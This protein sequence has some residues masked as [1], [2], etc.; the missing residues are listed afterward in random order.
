MSNNEDNVENTGAEE[1][2]VPTP[3]AEN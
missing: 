2:V 3:V 1:T